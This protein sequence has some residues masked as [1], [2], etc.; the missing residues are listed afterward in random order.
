MC[1][2]SIK[3]KKATQLLYLVM[4]DNQ[5]KNEPLQRMRLSLDF[6]IETYRR[7]QKLIERNMEL[8]AGYLE[9]GYGLPKGTDVFYGALKMYEAVITNAQPGDK[10]ELNI[11]RRVKL[12]FELTDLL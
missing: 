6:S 5:P 2:K 8:R 9:K 4:D 3:F 11:G 12:V 1:C 10:I 7:F